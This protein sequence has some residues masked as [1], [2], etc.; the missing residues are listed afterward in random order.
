MLAKRLVW[1]GQLG[2]NLEGLCLGRELADGG[3]AIV[4]IGDNGGLDTPSRIVVF[5][6]ASR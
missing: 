3:R 4:G 5:G 6:L 1:K 2:I